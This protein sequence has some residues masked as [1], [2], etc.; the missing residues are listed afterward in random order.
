MWSTWERVSTSQSCPPRLIFQPCFPDAL[1]SKT[2]I[3]V[4]Y[5][6]KYSESFP[7]AK[8]LWVNARTA[9]Q[10]E[11]SYKVITEDL[12]IR[13][14]RSNIL[15]AVHRYLG[16]E[17]NGNWLM[18]LDGVDDEDS[19]LTV[20]TSERDKAKD[21]KRK[22]LLDYVPTSMS[23]RVLITS[24][25][26]SLASNLVNQKPEYVIEV[27]TLADDDA[28]FL[29]Y[30]AVPKDVAKKQKALELAGVSGQSPLAIVLAAAYIRAQGSGFLVRNYLELLGPGTSKPGDEGT[31]AEK[32]ETELA[33]D[34]AWQISYKFIKD[35]DAEAARLVL[36]IAT[37]DLQSI[38]SFLLAKGTDARSQLD[39][40]I[41]TLVNLGLIK[42]SEDRTEVSVTRLIQLSA[43]RLVSRADDPTWAEERALS[44]VTAAFPATENEEYETCEILYPCAVVVLKFQPKTSGGKKD[45]AT[46]LYKIAGYNKYLGRYEAALQCLE[47]C[48]KLREE[49][50]DKDD[51]L[52]QEA[53]KAVEDVR[54]E[55]RRAESAPEVAVSG[56]G[57]SG[58]PS[59]A[60]DRVIGK[61]QSLM[62]TGPQSLSQEQQQAVVVET[63]AE[64]DACEKALGKDHEDTLRKA[65]DLAVAL[66]RRD[67]TGESIAIRKRVLDWC[68][69][70]YGPRSLDTVRQTY[71]L[72]LAYDVQGQ[73]DEAAELYHTAFKGA[74]SLLAPGSPELLRILSNLA[75]VYVA[76]GKMAE[77]EEALRVALAGQQAKL[78]PDHPETLVTRQNAALAA[79][80]LGKLEVAEQDL[81]HVLRAQE[82]VLGAD[83]EVTLRTACSLALNFRLRGRH[84]E[85][86]ALYNLALNGQRKSLGDA[87]PD[88]LMTR[89]MLG[90]LFQ[91]EGKLREAREEYTAVLDGRKKVCGE[92]HPDTVY[93]KSRL[94]AMG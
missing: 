25:S 38:R 86:E 48:L 16:Q 28:V 69:A 1:D 8:V 26:M 20:D 93:V 15:K 84:N 64:L 21:A 70:R 13:N 22:S 47:D 81:V 40:H 31:Q 82:R 52:I 79:Q 43:R 5:A 33:A 9:D 76:Q 68:T 83:N 29:L 12:R 90:E 77:A 67:P 46:L 54:G 61:A 24:R 89:L 57:Q 78:G 34:K 19:L 65:D 35:K 3:A 27:Q 94:E 44:L 10:F 91:G 30:G 18:V 80:A 71:N 36:I 37:F 39:E 51:A 73:Y 11:R 74:E 72:A 85:A 6:H 58:G 53:K 41:S 88:T 87:H 59:S 45:R 63:K 66:H 32:S 14:A 4:E 56:F 55:Q 23:G 60:W 92:A 7:G 42:Q 2:H 62:R 75:V 17:A 50:L 49:L